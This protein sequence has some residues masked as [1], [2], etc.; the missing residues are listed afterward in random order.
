MNHKLLPQIPLDF[1]FDSSP[2]ALADLLL[3]APRAELRL[4]INATSD[5]EDLHPEDNS[6]DLAVPLR[7][8]HQVFGLG[9][10][11]PRE[12]ARAPI[13]PHFLKTFSL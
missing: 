3:A 13:P 8:D 6:L 2:L 10:A 11:M 4:L 5:S 7:L 1:V 9:Y 12:L